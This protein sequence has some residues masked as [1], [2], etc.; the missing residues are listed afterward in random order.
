MTAKTGDKALGGEGEEIS[1]FAFEITENMTMEFRGRSCN[2]LDGE[3]NLVE[4]L[5]A[6]H[7][8]VTREI[9]AGY[10]CYVMKAWIKFQKKSV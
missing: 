6:E 2:I 3:G 4:K 9:L 8:L 5:G 10:R 7:G 1:A